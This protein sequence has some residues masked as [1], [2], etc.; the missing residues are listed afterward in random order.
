MY[1]ERIAFMGVMKVTQ[2]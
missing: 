1:Q 2:Y